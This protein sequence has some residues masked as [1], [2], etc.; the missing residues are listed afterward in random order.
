MR[1]VKSVQIDTLLGRIPLFGGLSCNETLEVG[2]ACQTLHLEKNEMLF[3]SGDGCSGLLIVM[4]GQVKVAFSSPL[5]TEKVVTILGAGQSFGQTELILDQPYRAHA[6]ALDDTLVLQISKTAILDLVARNPGFTHNL[7]SSLSQQTH[8]LMVDLEGY[9][10]CSGAKRVLTFLLREAANQESCQ[11][12]TVIRLSAP[13][14]V[15]ASQLSL[16][17]EHFSRTL[18]ELS[19]QGLFTIQGRDIH[20]NSI[21]RLQL[22]L[23]A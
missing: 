22:D 6:Q 9:T 10:L 23:V 16:S 15:I 21:S 3:R 20:I 1:D 18:H 19:A 8:D 7:L 2:K 5:G 4:Y 13:K 17:P 12:A 14:S 11:E